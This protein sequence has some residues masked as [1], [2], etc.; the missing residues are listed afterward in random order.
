MI[1]R[2]F[3]KERTDGVKLYRTYSD[4][5]VYIRK[6]GTEEIY[7][8]AVDIEEALHSYEETDTEIEEIEEDQPT[9]ANVA[10]TTATDVP[11]NVA[12]EVAQ[13]VK[14]ADEGA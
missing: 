10:E 6:V 13:V 1:V 14:S 7:T 9:I 12:T 8:E 5:G 2:E 4:K 11:T 3:Y